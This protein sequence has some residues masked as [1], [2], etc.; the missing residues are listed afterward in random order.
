VK[1]TNES[2]GIT[3]ADYIADRTRDFVGREWVFAEI[4]AWLTDPDVPRFFI[5]TGEPGIGKTAIA[6]RLIQI[7]DL[8]AHHF[9]IA[10]QADTIDPYDFV[11]NLSLQ[12]ARIEGFAQELLEEQ[13]IH[14]E[15]R[16]TIQENYGQ[17]IGVKIENLRLQARSATI[18]SNRI[19]GDPLKRLYY[20]GF[21]RPLLI[22][23][24]ALDKAVQLRAEETIVD[25][26]AN[27][28]GLPKETRF[29]L[30]SRPEGEVLRH[31]ERF[32]IPH[33][34]LDAGR[35]ENQQDVR[36]YVKAR[37]AGSDAPQAELAAHTVNAAAVVD[38]I[39][40]ASGGN[41][42]YLVWLLRDLEE[43]PQSFA[44]LDDLPRGLDG[45][46][47]EFLGTQ[48]VGRDLDRWEEEYSPLL[49]VLAVAQSPLT[50]GQLTRFADLSR[51]KVHRLLRRVEQFIGPIGAKRDAYRLYPSRWSISW[52]MNV[53]PESS[54]SIYKLST[55]GLGL[56][57]AVAMPTTGPRAIAMG[58]NTWYR[59]S[60]RQGIGRGS[61]QC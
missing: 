26:L 23:L 15:S 61:P 4:D 36:R 35:E 38:E 58:W 48:Q 20:G 45:I 30:A 41:F 22:L 34:V 54:G 40:T 19:I 14:I 9:C 31:F 10:R 55:G 52:G 12:L 47:R 51:R 37:L 28:Q 18:I 49:G 1:Q 50:L 7:R 32:E 17:A 5:I 29:V 59:T 33:L 16:L 3:W 13:H 56:T 43:G 60:A 8:D 53:A 42:L 57:V 6:A 2:L 11:H 25:L 27:A 39:A 21:G 46:Y 24:D 44:A